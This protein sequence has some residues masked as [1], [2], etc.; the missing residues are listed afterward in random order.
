MHFKKLNAVYKKYI[1]RR[2]KNVGIDKDK[3]V[4]KAGLVTEQKALMR[5]K[6]TFITIKDISEDIIMMILY[7]R[8]N[9]ALKSYSKNC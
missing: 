8:S 9:I 3:D 5:I 2:V 4:K 7:E 6:Q 1:H